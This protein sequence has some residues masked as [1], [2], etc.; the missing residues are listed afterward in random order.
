MIACVRGSVLPL[1]AAGFCLALG[2]PAQADC[3]GVSGT[4]DGFDKETAVSRAH[5][6]A[7]CS[8]GATICGA[9]SSSRF[10]AYHL[11]M[12]SM[13]RAA[14]T[15]SCRFAVLANLSRKL[16]KTGLVGR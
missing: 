8:Y 12:I 10:E 16:F 1:M 4:A 9:S 3:V 13:R 5:S 7:L 2:A 11:P 6:R 15:I 14:G